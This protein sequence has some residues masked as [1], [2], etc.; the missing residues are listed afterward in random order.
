MLLQDFYDLTMAYL[1]RAKAD[2]VVHA[3]IFFDP[4]T[5]T[6]RGIALGDVIA[7]I[8]RAQKEAEQSLGMSSHLILSFLRDQGP[9]AALQTLAEVDTSLCTPE[10]TCP[11]CRHFTRGSKVAVEGQR[12]I[13]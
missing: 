8:S 13:S 7:G 5:H 4:Q 11:G 10:H 1:R 12:N 9:Q 2:N 3:E 6:Q